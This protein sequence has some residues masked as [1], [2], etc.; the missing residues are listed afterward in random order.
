MEVSGAMEPTWT[1][2]ELHAK[3]QQKGGT[4][5]LTGECHNQHG[6]LVAQA[7]G[8]MLVHSRP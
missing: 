2:T 4:V 8:K 1:V 5:V 6:E 3:S 7:D